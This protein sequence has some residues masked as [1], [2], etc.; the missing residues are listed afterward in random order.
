MQVRIWGEN[1]MRSPAFRMIPGAG[2]QYA[3]GDRQ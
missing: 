2:R 3:T 1:T